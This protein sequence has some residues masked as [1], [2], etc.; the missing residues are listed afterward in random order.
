[1]AQASSTVK[2]AVLV[3]LLTTTAVLAF[4]F[5]LSSLSDEYPER[6]TY[7]LHAFFE[8]ASG[9]YPQSRV[10][11]AGIQIGHVSDIRLVDGRARVEVAILNKHPIWSNGTISKTMASIM[12]DSQLSITPGVQAE[13][14]RILEDGDEI[15]HVI[16]EAGLEDIKRTV[17]E[18]TEDVKSIT[19]TTNKVLGTPESAE[20]L[21]QIITN[22]AEITENLNR[23]L[24]AN[25]E[26]VNKTVENVEGIT[27]ESRPQIQEILENI[28]LASEDIRVL[29]DENDE[30]VDETIT[31]LRGSLKT[32]ESAIAKLDRTMTN[33]E[34]AS[35]DIAEQKGALGKLIG[36]EQMGD[37]VAGAVEGASELV[38]SVT[39]LQTIVGLRSEYNFFANSL[40]TYVSVMI[41]PREDKYYLIEVVDDPRGSHTVEVIDITSTHPEDPHYWHETRE[42][43]TRRFKFSF[44]FARKIS[45]ATFR[46]GIKE[47]TGGIGVDFHFLKGSLRFETDLYDF[48]GN[49]YPRLKVA[50]AL[51]FLR[52]IYII[53]GVDDV[54]NKQRDYFIG[55]QLRF[56]DEDLKAV[57]LFAP[58]GAVTQ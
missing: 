42:K 3:G 19:E 31:E 32:L 35:D 16:E 34:Q 51:R 12:G 1:M 9:L 13:G 25:T 29:V 44:M 7:R 43:T 37:D 22:L 11:M 40:K 47:S 14:E 4:Y 28:R 2:N 58:T 52:K 23:T 10:N 33:V 39:N 57:L 27:S 15:E 56:N 49:V 38:S 55:A 36:D 50:A 53:G 30:Q 6:D 20:K 45:F 26:L 54:L 24:E 41:Q 18:I 5:A 21:E 48:T 46:F 8:D 17:T